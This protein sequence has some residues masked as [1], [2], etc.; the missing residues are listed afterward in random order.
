M[1]FYPSDEPISKQTE[2]TGM[3]EAVVNFTSGLNGPNDVHC[4]EDQCNFRY[5]RQFNDK[6][7]FKFPNLLHLKITSTNSKEVVLVVEDGE[8]LLGT[9]FN[10]LRFFKIKKLIPFIII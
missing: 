3:A 8:F 7:F 4:S 2:V 10:R 9:S 6:I 1:F 5:V